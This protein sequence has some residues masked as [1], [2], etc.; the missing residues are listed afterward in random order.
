M[1]V[2]TPD[3]AFMFMRNNY[4]RNNNLY[5]QET[6]DGGLTWT[7]PEITNLTNEDSSLVV[8]QIG[9]S[10]YLM[11]HNIDKRSKLSLAVSNDGTS[12]KDM[13]LLENVLGEEFSYPAIQVHDGLV[14]ILY[15]WERKY[16]KHV[17][18]NLNWLDQK[19]LLQG[20]SVE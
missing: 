7:K 4:R 9:I 17:R 13:V 5:Y 14:D 19:I 10:K 11:V 20:N 8:A 2:T 18:F 12:W 3:H 15:T 6:N 1:L 16:I